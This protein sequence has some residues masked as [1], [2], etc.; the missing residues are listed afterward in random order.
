MC[1]LS[2][3]VPIRKK[4]GNFLWAP[5]MLY[6]LEKSSQFTCKTLYIYVYI[7]M[8]KYCY[9]YTQRHTS[10]YICI[11]NIYIH[12]LTHIYMDTRIHTHSYLHWHY[13]YIYIYI[14]YTYSNLFFLIGMKIMCNINF[15]CRFCSINLKLFPWNFS[16]LQ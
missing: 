15:Y 2:I 8:Q 1:V 13:I 11:K 14:T 6:Y 4:S 12:T 3:K 10:I 16:I 5:C 7:P 9:T